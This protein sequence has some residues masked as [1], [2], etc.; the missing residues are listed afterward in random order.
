MERVNHFKVV[1]KFNDGAEDAVYEYPTRKIAE[2]IVRRYEK[3]E[4]VLSVELK[5][6]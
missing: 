1:V 5:E 2:G 3:S 6:I 4:F